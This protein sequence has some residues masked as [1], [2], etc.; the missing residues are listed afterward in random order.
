MLRFRKLKFSQRTK[1]FLITLLIL[2]AAFFAANLDYPKYWNKFSDWTNGN[3]TWLHVPKFDSK[4][5]SLGLDLQGGIHL[6]YKADLN[7]IPDGDEQNAVSALR[8]AIERRVNF[9]GVSEPVVQIQENENDYRLIVELA[10]ITNPGQAIEQ[11]GQTPFLEFK[12]PRPKIEQ[13]E[14]LKRA[15]PELDELSFQQFCETA[16][17]INVLVATNNAGEDPCF[18]S[19]GLTGR[20]LE[21]SSVTTHPQTGQIEVTLQ[22]NKEGSDLFA[23]I[24]ERNI[25]NVVAI[26]LDQFPVSVPQVNEKITGGSA[27][28]T[29]SFSVEQARELASNLNSG[30]LPVPIEL[31][32]Q[33]RVGASL[34][35]KSLSS[36]L[37]AGLV[38]VITVL[39]FLIIFYRFSGFLATVSLVIYLVFLLTIIKLVPITLTLAGIAGLILSIGMAVDANI[40]VFERLREEVGGDTKNIMRSIDM[41]FSRAWPSVRDGNVSTLITVTILFFFSTSFVQGFALTLGLGILVSLFSAMVVTRILMKLL[42]AGR[43]GKWKWIWSR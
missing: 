15:F 31:I 17:V 22:F 37:F 9:L 38:G 1:L 24:T 41:A 19:T 18:A 42:A 11:I 16:S 10:G 35:E 25:G 12:E 27:T 29:G 7:G 26:Y 23:E 21:R 13:I 28:I 20:Y 6:V 39:I 8:D 30:A 4:E 3:V 14:I 33:Q 34:G 43:L 2:L 32:S 36:S 5:Y 40:L